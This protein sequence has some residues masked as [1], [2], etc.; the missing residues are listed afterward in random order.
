M[1]IYILYI[2]VCIYI[3]VSSQELGN[4]GWLGDLERLRIRDWCLYGD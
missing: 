2:Y 4:K 1:Y 3:Y